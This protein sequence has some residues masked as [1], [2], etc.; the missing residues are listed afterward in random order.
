MPKENPNCPTS[1]RSGSRYAQPDPPAVGSPAVPQG[2]QQ[3]VLTFVATHTAL[4]A[5]EELVQ[6][7]DAAMVE[8]RP[9][10]VVWAEVALDMTLAANTE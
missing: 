5:H 10:A 1:T 9:A 3:Y 2:H 4:A 7:G 8:E 6:V